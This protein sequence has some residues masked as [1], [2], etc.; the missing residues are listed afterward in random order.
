M[1][2]GY[3]KCDRRVE[4]GKMLSPSSLDVHKGASKAGVP[5]GGQVVDQRDF[6]GTLDDIAC[7]L[8]LKDGPIEILGNDGSM[9]ASIEEYELLLL[10]YLP[11]S[12]CTA[13]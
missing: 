8:E 12:H 9:P 5:F 6:T 1:P 7:T 13:T 10:S 2:P 11:L 4:H 3:P